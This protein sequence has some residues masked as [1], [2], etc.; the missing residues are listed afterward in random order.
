MFLVCV[1][2]PIAEY[3]D[4]RER[5]LLKAAGRRSDRSQT[6][7]SSRILQWLTEEFDAAVELRKRL[8]AVPGVTASLR[9]E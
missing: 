7:A 1:I 8:A 6:D 3:G 9:E 5:K 2:Y 4:S